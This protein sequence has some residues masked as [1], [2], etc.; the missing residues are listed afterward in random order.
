MNITRHKKSLSNISYLIHAYCTAGVRS[1]IQVVS[2]H[3]A[4]CILVLL[5]LLARLGMGDLLPDA[6]SDNVR[7]LEEACA[8]GTEAIEGYFAYSIALLDFESKCSK[9]ELMKIDSMLDEVVVYVEK[10][11]PKYTGGGEI[12]VSKCESNYVNGRLLRSNLPD[13][14]HE[15]EGDAI[16]SHHR[17]LGRY[18]RTGGGYCRR[19]PDRRLQTKE[20]ELQKLQLAEMELQD[21][22]TKEEQLIREE[23][24]PAL[25]IASRTT[26][27]EWLQGF[28]NTIAKH[29]TRNLQG[30]ECVSSVS[31]V[32]V[33]IQLLRDPSELPC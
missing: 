30:I 6:N 9:M 2:S 18:T 32:E 12:F 5:S 16:E 11:Y 26:L 15:N 1:Q 14:E 29:V 31:R 10:N 3:M 21:A 17:R 4:L 24:Y 8:P 13:T 28:E 27:E 33:D 22:V 19:C 23:E 7:D 25:T 20:E